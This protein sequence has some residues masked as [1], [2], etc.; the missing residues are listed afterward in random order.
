MKDTFL[1]HKEYQDMI[2]ALTDE[3]AG[4]FLKAMMRYAFEGEDPEVDDQSVRLTFIM[5]R[6]Y[7]DRMTEKYDRICAVNREN[8]SKGGRPRKTEE[9]PKKPNGYFEKPKKTEENP[10]IT[11][12]N[13]TITEQNPEKPLCE[14]VIC[15]DIYNIYNSAKPK[16]P[17]GFDENRP[18]SKQKALPVYPHLPVE[19]SCQELE[20]VWMEFRAMRQRIRKP[21]TRRAEEMLLKDLLELSGG[22]TGPAI[23][24]VEQSIKNS[25]QGLF[26][27]RETEKPKAEWQLFSSKPKKEKDPSRDYAQAATDLFVSDVLNSAQGVAM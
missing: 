10:T 21:M 26:P 20:D 13:P 14:D 6:K 11:E 8:G 25:Y 1:I 9:N 16:K 7:I 15:E 22:K 27:L 3:Q 18:V 5:V 2:D 4:A 19:L 12:Q 24:I 17:T 23:K